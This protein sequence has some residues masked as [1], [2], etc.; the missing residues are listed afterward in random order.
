M[1]KAHN[2]G[3]EFR[4]VGQNLFRYSANGVY[5]AI[6]KI[7]GKKI[8]KSLESTDRELTQ[9][10]LKEE[11]G[12]NGLVDPAQSAMTLAELI[13][14]S[15]NRR[16]PRPGFPQGPAQ[17]RGDCYPWGRPRSSKACGWERRCGFRRRAIS[18]ANSRWAFADP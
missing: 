5:Y 16:R 11:L 1:G 4:K 15:R 17:P 8:W 18:A 3:G 2:R 13:A 7:A 10:R 12:K 9:R 14:S 6:S